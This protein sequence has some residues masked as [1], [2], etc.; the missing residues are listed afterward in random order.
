MVDAFFVVKGLRYHELQK[1]GTTDDGTRFI[2]SDQTTCGTGRQI[3]P[4]VPVGDGAAHVAP[5]M[6]GDLVGP[7]K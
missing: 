4:F 5:L 3:G 7:Q 1:E 6:R 2:K